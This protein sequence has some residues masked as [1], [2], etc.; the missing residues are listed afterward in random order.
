MRPPLR[1]SSKP[2]ALPCMAST[3]ILSR[4]KS[5]SAPRACR[6]S[7]AIETTRI[8]NVAA[9]LEDSRGL[10]GT[11]PYRSPHH[12]ICHAGPK[13]QTA[14]SYSRKAHLKVWRKSNERQRGDPNNTIHDIFD[15]LSHLGEPTGNRLNAI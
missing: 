9:V 6:I 4:W 8:H 2:K 1:C 3:P 10:V 14:S 12:T 11:R 13:G 15:A 7:E 5:T